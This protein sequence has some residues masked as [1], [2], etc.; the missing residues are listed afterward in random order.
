MPRVALADNWRRDS[1]PLPAPQPDQD[2]DG[3]RSEVGVEGVEVPRRRRNS[4][5]RPVAGNLSS[6]L[7][8]RGQAMRILPSGVTR[9]YEARRICPPSRATRATA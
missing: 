9:K 3:V 7:R 6:S 2:V 5:Q 4:V 8:H 1:H